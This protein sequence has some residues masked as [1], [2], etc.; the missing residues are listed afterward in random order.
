V[1]KEISSFN[2][3]LQKC[4]KSFNGVSLI[5]TDYARDN[6]TRLGMYLNSLGKVNVARQIMECIYSMINREVKA[7]I[8]L[9]WK[10]DMVDSKMT[11]SGPAHAT[12]TLEADTLDK[13]ADGDTTRLRSEVSLVSSVSP[14]PTTNTLDKRTRRKPMMRSSDFLWED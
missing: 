3:K 2:K 8:S 12:V 4:L 10:R 1:N 6:F 13:T 14:R 9:D 7:P 11:E 5:K